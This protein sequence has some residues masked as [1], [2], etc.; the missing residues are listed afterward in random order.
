MRRPHVFERSA[1]RGR[2]PALQEPTPEAARQIAEVLPELVRI[3]E[4]GGQS[5]L[6]YLLTLAKLDAESA[7]RRA[8]GGSAPSP[9][10]DD[11]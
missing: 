11:N 8:V 6:A 3:A 2:R 4:A 5:S 7:I 1:P 9:A 10:D